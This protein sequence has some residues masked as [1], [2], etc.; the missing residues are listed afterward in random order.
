MPVS[1]ERAEP[2]QLS[3]EIQA[4]MFQQAQMSDAELPRGLWFFSTPIKDA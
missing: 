3:P 2:A 1:A 4:A